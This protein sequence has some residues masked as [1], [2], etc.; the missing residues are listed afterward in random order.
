[1]D[2]CEHGDY[3]EEGWW[4]VDEALRREGRLRHRTTDPQCWGPHWGG[5]LQNTTGISSVLQL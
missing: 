3:A 2:E 5:G 1:M 4:R